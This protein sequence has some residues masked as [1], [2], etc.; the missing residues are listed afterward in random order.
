MRL[1]KLNF[2]VMAITGLLI[3]GVVIGEIN[4]FYA[5][6]IGLYVNDVSIEF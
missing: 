6:L 5:A 3:V 2:S 4:W 1:K